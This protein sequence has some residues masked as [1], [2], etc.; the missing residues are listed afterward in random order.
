MLVITATWKIYDNTSR[1][2][3]SVTTIRCACTPPS[4]INHRQSLNRH[5]FRPRLAAA[6]SMSFLGMGSDYRP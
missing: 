1:S 6:A 4:A 3:S 5:Q 2:L